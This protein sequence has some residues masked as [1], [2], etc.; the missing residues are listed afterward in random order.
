M[1]RA[2][3][4][5]CYRTVYCRIAVG[6]GAQSVCRLCVPATVVPRPSAQLLISIGYQRWDICKQWNDV[7]TFPFV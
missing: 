1:Q 5:G 3:F 2:V 4:V 6:Y 7:Q